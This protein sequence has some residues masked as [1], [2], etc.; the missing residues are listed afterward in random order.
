M[1]KD[2]KEKME[3]KNGRYKKDPN[4]TSKEKNTVSKMKN[5]LNRINSRLET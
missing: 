5:T 3:E 1:L 2:V 4:E